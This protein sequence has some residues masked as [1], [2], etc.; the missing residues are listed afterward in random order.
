MTNTAIGIAGE[1]TSGNAAVRIRAADHKSSCRIDQ[2]FYVGDGKSEYDG[3]IN[4]DGE[5]NISD[6]VLLSKFLI[7]GD[8]F[9]LDQYIYADLNKDSNVDVYDMVLM[10]A[11]LI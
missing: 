6:A 3:D 11:Y 10:R 1:L 8:K 5:V 7:N 9:T 4:G 2:L